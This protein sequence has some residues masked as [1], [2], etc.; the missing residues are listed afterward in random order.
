MKLE[1]IAIVSKI[2]NKDSESAA[3]NVANKLLAKKSTVYTI[4]PVMVEGAKQIETLEEIKNIKLDLIITLGGDGT[5]LRVFRNIENE[6]PI[7]TINVGG[8]RGILAEITIEEIDE[9]IEEILKDNFFLDKR[10]RVT[11]S[12]GGKES[13]PALNEIYISRANLT[14]TAEIEIKFQND[15]V[16]QKM[17]G[18]IIATPSGSTGH[19]FSL[20]GPILHE[21]L[22][23]LIITPVAPV[24]RLASLVVPDEKIQ[25]ICSQD[26]N[27]AIDAQVIRTAGYE[28]PIIIKKY[29]SPAVFIRLKKRGL[30]Q[31]SKLGF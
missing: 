31:M 20:G 22:D 2:G 3:K 1:N 30:R 13:P 11:A 10:T 16:K 14:K 24:Y 23:V 6:T 17:D 7:L 12:C 15:T 9:A 26:C 4:S 29:K 25:I 28:E 19:S 5:T 21:S 27:I 8:N 18:V